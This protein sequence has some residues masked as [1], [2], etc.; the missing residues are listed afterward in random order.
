M[1]SINRTPGSSAISSSDRKP[2]GGIGGKTSPGRIGHIR[3][4]LWYTPH[5]RFQLDE[6]VVHRG[7][8]RPDY[9]LVPLRAKGQGLASYDQR[10]A[11]QRKAYAAHQ[12]RKA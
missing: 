7:T 3:V 9:H 1:E 10:E 11:L 4:S 5:T 12:L 2:P 8:T 6:L